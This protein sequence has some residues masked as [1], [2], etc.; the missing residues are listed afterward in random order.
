M[1]VFPHLLQLRYLT[2]GT[3]TTTTTIINI[4][5]LLL[6]YHL[7]QRL[8]KVDLLAGKFHLYPHQ[9]QHLQQYFHL[10]LHLHSTKDMRSSLLVIL[11]DFQGTQIVTHIWFLLEHPS[12]HL[13][14]LPRHTSKYMLQLLFH[15]KSLHQVH[16]PVSYMLMFILRRGVTL[17]HGL[18]TDLCQLHPCHLHLLKGFFCQSSGLSRCSYLYYFCS[19]MRRNYFFV[20]KLAYSIVKTSSTPF[21]P[22]KDTNL[23]S[24]Q[25]ES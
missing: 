5:T 12:L 14:L 16:Y 1:V 21:H 6:Q 3:T 17:L 11:G 24:L 8:G 18:L 15:M 23:R 4:Q 25:R 9:R 13:I 22:G 20:T 10:P 7:L 2:I 19:S